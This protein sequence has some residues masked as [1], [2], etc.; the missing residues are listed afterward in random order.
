MNL[1]G[2]IIGLLDWI[3]VTNPERIIQSLIMLACS[4]DHLITISCVRKI[5]IPSSP[6]KYI[7]LRQCMFQFIPFADDAWNF[8][9]SEGTKVSDN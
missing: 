7:D 5:K 9:Y 8:F 2:W 1:V 3:L 6:P 4:I